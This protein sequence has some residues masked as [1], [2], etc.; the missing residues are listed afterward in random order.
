MATELNNDELK[1]RLPDLRRELD[2]FN[3][4]S[5]AEYEETLDRVTSKAMSALETIIADGTLALDPEQLVNSVKVL[6]K[7][8][9]DIYETRRRLVETVVKGEVMMRALEPPEDKKKGG[10]SS[11]LEEY[12]Q[13]NTMIGAGST[14]VFTQIDNE[15]KKEEPSL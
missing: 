7:A 11:V 13:R 8:K 1:E 14:S 3:K 9:T 12:L 6:T 5:F 15:N 2:L 10:N 4:A